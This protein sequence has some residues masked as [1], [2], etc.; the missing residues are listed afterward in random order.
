M[1]QLER[2]LASTVSALRDER[3]EKRGQ[4]EALRSKLDKSRGTVRDME[5]ELE[6]WVARAGRAA[7]AGGLLLV[8]VSDPEEPRGT[9]IPSPFP[10]VF[11]GLWVLGDLV[12]CFRPCVAHLFVR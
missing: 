1:R 4:T 5:T 6:R 12:S 3:R 9:S 2:E 7:T 11:V 10:S 8:R